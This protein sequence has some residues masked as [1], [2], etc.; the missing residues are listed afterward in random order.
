VAHDLKNLRG[1]TVSLSEAL[2]EHQAAMP[3]KEIDHWLSALARGS[4]RAATIVD[5]LPLLAAVRA[6]DQVSVLPVDMTAAVADV[7][8]RLAPL[9]AEYRAEII[10]PESWPVVQSHAPWIEEV[11][12]NYVSSAIKYGG[13]P[14]RVALGATEGG[15]QIR[16]WVTDSGLGLTPRQQSR[17]FAPFTRL[18]SS[19]GEGEGLGLSIVQRIVE[20]LGGE[21]GVES[22]VGQGSTFWFSLPWDAGAETSRE[23]IE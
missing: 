16:F 5:E 9:V 12:V 8:D 21:V 13:Q 22:T 17:L 2:K 18:G 7:L 3:R 23:P 14:P 4:R 15:G 1:Y 11:W 6:A 20:K 19:R 10:V